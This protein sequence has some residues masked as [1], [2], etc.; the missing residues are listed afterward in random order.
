VREFALYCLFAVLLVPAA[1]AFGG[2]AARHL[3]GYP[4]GPAWEQWFLGNALAHLVVTPFIFYWV[5]GAPWNAPARFA[6]RWVEGALLTAGLIVTAYIAFHTEAGTNVFAEPRF[7]APVP[8]LFWAA[9]RYGMFGATGAIAVIAI[10]SVA[11]ALQGHGPFSGQSPVDTAIALQ[12]FLS[13][14]AAPLYLVAVLIEQ[15]RGIENCLRE[16][17]ERFRNMAEYAPVMVWVTEPNASCSYLSKSWYEF[18]GQTPETALGFGWLNSVHTDDREHA[19]ETFVAANDRR[20]PFRLDYRL[21]RHDGEYRWVI[22]SAA[23]RFGPHGDFLG[24]I[25]S[26]LDI[27]ERSRLEARLHTQYAI[28]RILSEAASMAEALPRVLQTICEQLDCEYGEIWRINREANVL[29]CV[30]VWH[31]PLTPL[32]EFESASR[33]FVFPLGLGLPGRVWQTGK[34]VCMPDVTVDPNFLRPTA[35]ASSGVRGALG[36][37]ILSGDEVFGVI[38]LFAR[39]IRQADKDR[40]EMLTSIGSQV[41]QFI[42]RNSAEDRNNELLHRLGERVKELTALHR[43]ARILQNEEQPMADLL[44]Q[45]VAVLPPAWQYPEITAARIRLGE[46]EFAT[47]NFKPTPWT[48]R[49]DFSVAEGLRGTIEVV[50][51]EERPAE[52][53]GPFLA[54][55]R[56]LIDSLAEVL[57][58]AIERRQAQEQIGLLQTIAMEVGA[59]DDLSS[60]LA[61]VLRRVCEKTGWAIGQ[62]WI[63]RYDGSVLDCS[64]AW[65]CVGTGL[66]KFRK[67]SEAITLLPGVGLPGRVWSS[68]QPAWIQDAT[69]DPNFPRL[70]VA[71]EAGLKGALGI[72]IV[73][74]DE[75]LAVIEFFIPEPRLEDERLVKVITAVGAQLGLVIERKRAD[76]MLRENETVLRA[77]YD[78]IQD[79]AGRLITAQEAERSRIAGELHDDVNQQLAGLSIALSNVKRQLQNGGYGTVQEELNRLQQRTIDLAD[80]IRNLSHELHPGVLQHAGLAAALNGHCADFGRQH[81]I[82]MTLSA[83]DNLDGIPHEV[84]L[85]LYRVTQE[86]LRNIAEHAGAQNAQV[87]L[88]STD[89]GLELVIADDGQGFD[90]DEA[91]GLGG[92]GLISLDERVRL[93]GGSLAISTRPQHGTELRVQVPL[94]GIQ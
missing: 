16:S 92:L 83:A 52:Q 22:D 61:V 9:I 75:V 76:E 71:V 4:Y 93:I 27:T 50:Y 24:Y 12:L 87:T 21:R 94:G 79:L 62:A 32:T 51:L 66:E 29:T 48:Q 38:V 77:S 28:T 36:F 5:L 84:A 65:F 44:Q 23:P 80:V 64:P 39:E 40:L 19:H 26:V 14:R 46:L 89:N 82:E 60:A 59:A 69:L 72:P 20:E 86:A 91:R 2:A 49:A 74:G 30:E 15:R 1:S 63:P 7:Y 85:C 8:F 13:L 55:A 88:R 6:T 58:A 54:E 41:G 81:A 90:L 18:T 34:P 3:L 53:E 78:R 25:G 45:F 68:K 43:A 17:E 31:L 56:S 67:Y 42:E 70:Q 73:S 37:P 33:A 11:A 10:F 57:R 47:P 35:A